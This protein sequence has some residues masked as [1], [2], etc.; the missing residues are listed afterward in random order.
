M[1]ISWTR[2]MARPA[3]GPALLA[4]RVLPS[5]VASK[6]GAVACEDGTTVS[7]SVA[8]PMF[9]VAAVVSLGMSWLLVSSLERVGERLGLSEAL[10]GVLAALAA[11]APE[12]TAAVTAL[13][14]HE[15]R[16]G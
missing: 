10:L 6:P 4:P 1:S 11:D 15:P 14:H 8:I 5:A 9:L 12:I 16:V 13:V 2:P 3:I 7:T